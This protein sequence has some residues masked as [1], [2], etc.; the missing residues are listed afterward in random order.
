MLINLISGKGLSQIRW[1]ISSALFPHI[2]SRPHFTM[3]TTSSTMQAWVYRSKGH[4]SKVLNLESNYPRPA[5]SANLVLV[6][7]RAISL[8]VRSTSSHLSQ[9]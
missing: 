9:S 1:P 6:K 4:P 5:P 3:S 2:S 8:N 7:V